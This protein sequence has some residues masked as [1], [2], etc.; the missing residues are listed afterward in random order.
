MVSKPN[1]DDASRKKGR[2][3]IEEALEKG[4]KSGGDIG[5]IG[6]G[7]GAVVRSSGGGR[8]GRGSGTRTEARRTGKSKSISKQESI[9]EQRKQ[10]CIW[11]IK[12]K[13]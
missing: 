9:I 7:T 10:D 4:F 3:K 8:G 6:G 11:I 12:K 2:E 1:S 13:K 5:D